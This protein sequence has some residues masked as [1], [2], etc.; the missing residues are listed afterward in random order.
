MTE[1]TLT[2]ILEH[3]PVIKEI[4]GEVAHAYLLSFLADPRGTN[5]RNRMSHGLMAAEEFTRG[6][7]DRVIHILLM[8]GTIRRK[9]PPGAGPGEPEAKVTPQ[10]DSA[11]FVGQGRRETGPCESY[12]VWWR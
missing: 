1:K 10:A 12:G 3:E 5:L 9:E 4:L 8:L 6:I 2:D 11:N 7:S